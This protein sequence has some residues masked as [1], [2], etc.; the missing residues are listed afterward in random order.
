MNLT[1]MSILRAREVHDFI[2]FII[3]FILLKT[4][5]SMVNNG[6]WKCTFTTIV[7]FMSLGKSRD[8][9]RCV[10]ETEYALLLAIT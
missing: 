4:S 2:F 9:I 1:K 10:C 7:R 8:N 5:V 6:P 3:S